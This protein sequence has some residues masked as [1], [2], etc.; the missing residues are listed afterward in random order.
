MAWAAGT[1]P[2]CGATTGGRGRIRDL[3]RTAPMPEKA[4]TKPLCPAFPRQPPS[5][6]ADEHRSARIGWRVPNEGNGE[7]SDP[8]GPEARATDPGSPDPLRLMLEGPNFSHMRT[9]STQ[10]VCSIRAFGRTLNRVLLASYNLSLTPSTGC[11]THLRPAKCRFLPSCTTCWS[12][13]V[14]FPMLTRTKQVSPFCMP[15]IG[16]IAPYSVSIPLSSA[17][18]IS[19]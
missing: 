7:A 17:N 12:M 14:S 8:G 6:Y 19:P 5:R 9:S 11:P 1:R 13:A 15:S 10:V 3:D 2:N 18:R 16:M 4:P